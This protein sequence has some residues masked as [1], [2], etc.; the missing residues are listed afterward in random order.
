[1]KTCFALYI[2][3]QSIE[4]TFYFYEIFLFAKNIYIY[5]LLPKFA[6]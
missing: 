2:G 4:L 1:M 3:L 5:F 6:S